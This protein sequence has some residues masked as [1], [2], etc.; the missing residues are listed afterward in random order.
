MK[1]V[2]FLELTISFESTMDQAHHR[3]LAKYYDLLEVARMAGYN[4]ECLA[5]EVGSR[6]LVIK[7]EL[8][9]LRRSLGNTTKEI[10]GFGVSLSQLAILGSFRVWCSRNRSME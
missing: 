1:M 8:Q 6:G 4:A 7:R 9:D 5:F 10:T 3:K 2:Y